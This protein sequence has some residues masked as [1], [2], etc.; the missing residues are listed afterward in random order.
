MGREQEV[1]KKKNLNINQSIFFKSPLTDSRS[2]DALILHTCSEIIQRKKRTRFCINLGWSISLDLP[3]SCQRKVNVFI[4]AN[5]YSVSIT[6]WKRRSVGTG[7]K[8]GRHLSREALEC[9]LLN[10]HFSAKSHSLRNVNRAPALWFSSE[11]IARPSPRSSRLTCACLLCGGWKRTAR[12]TVRS[13]FLVVVM[14]TVASADLSSL[15]AGTMVGVHAP[16]L[17]YVCLL[18]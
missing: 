2:T 4:L 1:V 6:C 14:K 9:A 8:K 3:A 5:S 10:L 18:Y 16:V 17:L 13:L 15:H 12:G 7:E 11:G